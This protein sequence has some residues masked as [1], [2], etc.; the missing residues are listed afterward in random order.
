M[1]AN[2]NNS[3]FIPCVPVLGTYRV[4]EWIIN[5]KYF[6]VT[7]EIP[8]RKQGYVNNMGGLYIQSLDFKN[9]PSILFKCWDT[10]NQ[11]LYTIIVLPSSRILPISPQLCNQTLKLVSSKVFVKEKSV[12]FQFRFENAPWNDS[13]CPNNVTF[14]INVTNGTRS[15]WK[16]SLYTQS[17]LVSRQFFEGITSYAEVYGTNTNGMKIAQLDYKIKLNIDGKSFV[18][19]KLIYLYIIYRKYNF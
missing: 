12:F 5:D 18:T 8:L 15:L 13:L 1:I 16:E 2:E 6:S 7:E 14:T 3:I 4:R 19:Y 10:G 11:F 9:E 17:F